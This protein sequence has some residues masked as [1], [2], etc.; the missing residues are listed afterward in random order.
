MTFGGLFTCL[1]GVAGS[2][3]GMTIAFVILA[4]AGIEVQ[5]LHSLCTPFHMKCVMHACGS[6]MI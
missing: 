1:I 3:F 6:H 2:S 4:A 5:S